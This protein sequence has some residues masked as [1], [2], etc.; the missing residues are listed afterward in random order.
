MVSLAVV[1]LTALSCGLAVHTVNTLLQQ[2]FRDRSLA[3]TQSF[4]SSAL[5]WLDPLQPTMLQSAAQF[6][7]VGS[8]QYVQIA[9]D[10]D[11]V[12]DERIDAISDRVI[13]PVAPDATSGIQSNGDSTLLDIVI[14]AFSGAS[15]SDGYVRIGIDTDS[16]RMES[17]TL[18]VQAG[19]LAL[20]VDGIVIG[21]LA[22]L[23]RVRR[24]RE[25][26][27]SG[28][29]PSTLPLTIGEL[30]IDTAS[31]RVIFR[32]HS[33]ALTPKQYALIA[34]LASEPDRVFTDR[35]IVD[36]V[37]E[38]SAYADSKDVKQY[39]YLVR[40]RLGA[41]HP[42]GKRVIQTVPGFGY[43]LVSRLVDEDLTSS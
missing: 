17:H 26:Q 20:G 18:A 2:S 21:L 16:V 42:D 30:T 11:L 25:K 19:A 4:A 37:W 9:L 35:E 41:I 22:W 24:P 33:V 29:S 3:Y 32:E 39:V 1:S 34:F 27:Q 31:R 43:K 14:P 15:L 5:P 12:V 6:M 38:S 7:L 13:E 23:W 40:R 36:N 28:S 8:A 10:G